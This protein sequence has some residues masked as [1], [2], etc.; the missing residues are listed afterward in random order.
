MPPENRPRVTNGAAA[1]PPFKGARNRSTPALPKLVGSA[2]ADTSE[3][4]VNRAQQDPTR[5]GSILAGSCSSSAEVGQ[6]VAKLNRIQATVEPDSATSRQVGG[7]RAA[8]KRH[9][10]GTIVK[11]ERLLNFAGGD[12]ALP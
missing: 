9:R 3:P 4:N 6:C 7:K 8:H 5:I 1:N 11:V 2:E 12:F 10:I